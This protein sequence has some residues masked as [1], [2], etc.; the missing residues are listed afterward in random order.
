MDRTGLTPPLLTCDGIF[1]H[2]DQ[3]VCG[4]GDIV[5]ELCGGNVSDHVEA[6]L[7]LQLHGHVLQDLIV[8]GVGAIKL[9]T[10]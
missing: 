2:A 7:C 4:R 1:W 6:V 10:E 5:G 3:S 8:K 9:K